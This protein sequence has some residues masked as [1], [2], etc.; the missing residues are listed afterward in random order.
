MSKAMSVADNSPAWDYSKGPD[1]CSLITDDPVIRITKHGASP[2]RSVSRPKKNAG[3]N[4]VD[5][6]DPLTGWIH[7][8]EGT[9][10]MKGLHQFFRDPRVTKVQPQFGPVS[11]LDRNGKERK[12][13]LDARVSYST[14]AAIVVSFKP[15]EIAAKTNHQDEL[16]CIFEQ[17]PDTICQGASLVT[18]RDLP[19]WAV[20]NGRLIFS[21]L[22]DPT[23]MLLDEMSD[24][25]RELGE[26]TTI[27]DFCLP[28]GGIATTFR[29]AVKLIAM[30]LIEAEPGLINAGTIV[31]SAT[32]VPN[33]AL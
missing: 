8:A 23:W 2:S 18:D 33:G 30:G 10:E 6:R 21:V 3:R 1:F 12:A 20:M 14:G 27:E 32:E 7:R 9:L 5:Y 19:E 31:R 4:T 24:S 29:T 26:P 13:H 28:F 15:A 17:L 16:Q 22:N 11:Y 25:A